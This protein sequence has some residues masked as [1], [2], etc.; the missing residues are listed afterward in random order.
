MK[1][2][3][4]QELL[5]TI[6]KSDKAFKVQEAALENITDIEFLKSVVSDNTSDC[7]YKEIAIKKIKDENYLIELFNSAHNF[8]SSLGIQ[9]AAIRNIFDQAFLLNVIKNEETYSESISA[10]AIENSTKE[11]FNIIEKLADHELE[12]ITYNNISSDILRS[13]AKVITNIDLLE[14]MVNNPHLYY[15]IK[16]IAKERLSEIKVSK[17]KYPE[18]VDT[19][20]KATDNR[21]LAKL[22]HSDDT[23]IR[24]AAIKRII[25]LSK[26]NQGN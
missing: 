5:K 17:G 2:I 22:T 21:V 15:E 12:K 1:N 26:S 20:R 4:D 10:I 16:D 23:I 14:K 19:I 18:S 9:E 24:D 7:Y 6:Y 13:S 3:E 11:N 25:E 8:E